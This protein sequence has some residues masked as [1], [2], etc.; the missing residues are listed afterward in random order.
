LGTINDVGSIIKTIRTHAPQSKILIDGSQAV[1]HISVDIS[2]LNPDFY[3][4]TG[5]KLY[6]PTGVGVLVARPDVMNALPPFMGGG[7]MID[8]V[9]LPTGTTYRTSPARFEPGTP[10]IIEV[11]GLGAAIDYITSIGW[12]AIT[13][14]EQNMSRALFDILKTIPDITIYGPDITAPRIGVFSF[15]VDWAHPSDIAMIL[16]QCGVAVRTGHHCAEPLHTHLGITGT[17]RTSIGLYTDMNDID[18]FA[19]AMKKAKRMLS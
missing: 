2:A 11:I 4:F 19:D 16:D 13:T 6:G 15:S 9:I 18:Q 5:H 8:H 17:I 14:H 10:A 7:D 1:P 12:S 3:V